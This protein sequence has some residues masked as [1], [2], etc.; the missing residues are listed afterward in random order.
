MSGHSHINDVGV[1]GGSE[2]TVHATLSGSTASVVGGSFTNLFV[3]DNGTSDTIT[4]GGFG[5]TSVSAATSAAFVQG[6]AG[7]LNFVGGAG[8]S[9]IIGGS[10]NATLTGG[11]TS[12]QRRRS[13]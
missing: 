4:A 13:R 10:G 8:N 3:T 9:T 12:L 5:F 11:A 2:E 7:L 1:T 6:G